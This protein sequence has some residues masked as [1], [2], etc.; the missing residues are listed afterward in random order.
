LRAALSIERAAALD[1]QADEAD[2]RDALERARDELYKA[3]SADPNAVQAYQE[4]TRISLQ[5]DDPE[6]AISAT[7]ALVQKSPGD[8]NALRNL[9]VIYS[10]TKQISKAIDYARQAFDLAPPEQR[11]VLEA[12]VQ[13]LSDAR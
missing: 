3:L 6:G 11:P 10:D 12:L 7:Q 5:L 8:W 4:L 1:R 13:Q 2:W 9:A